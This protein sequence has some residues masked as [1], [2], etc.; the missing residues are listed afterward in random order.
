LPI[1]RSR[2]YP[3]IRLQRLFH[4]R[5]KCL[6]IPYDIR[7]EMALRWL[8]SPTFLF[9]MINRPL[10]MAHPAM[11]LSG[12]SLHASHKAVENWSSSTWYQAYDPRSFLSLVF[13]NTEHGSSDITVASNDDSENTRAPTDHTGYRQ[14]MFTT[15]QSTFARGSRKRKPRGTSTRWAPQVQ[16]ALLLQHWHN[17]DTRGSLGKILRVVSAF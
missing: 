9:Y 17:V 8:T 5:S 10:T 2:H 1:S 3:L 15:R 6:D 4:L 12:A 11:E 14:P 16:T 7:H 13:T